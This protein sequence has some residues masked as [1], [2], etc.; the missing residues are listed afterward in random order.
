MPEIILTKPFSA[1][2]RERG[3]TPRMF[4]TERLS[5]T[6]RMLNGAIM[7]TLA[8]E[9]NISPAMMTMQIK[10]VVYAMRWFY[11]KNST[12]S[13][14]MSPRLT[15]LPEIR[16]NKAIWLKLL[17]RFEADLDAAYPIR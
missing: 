9:A 11:Q 3:Y 2:F 13:V 14:D 4:S 7:K 16:K 5:N 6:R 17:D 8:E 10:N 12:V 15:Q 1:L